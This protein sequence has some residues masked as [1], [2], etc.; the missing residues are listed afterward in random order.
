MS[1]VNLEQKLTANQLFKQYKDDGGTLNFSDWLTR[2]KK[3]GI[4]P[5]NDKLNEEVSKTLVDFKNKE[6]KKTVLGFPMSTIFI[7][8]GVIVLSIVAV[9]LMKKK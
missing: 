2:E 5:L 1:Q 3:K 6:M 9:Q 7:A 4:F 8:S